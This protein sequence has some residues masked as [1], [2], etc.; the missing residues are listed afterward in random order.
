MFFKFSE[1]AMS[2]ALLD[3][4]EQANLDEVQF[5]LSSGL[6]VNK[7]LVHGQTPLNLSIALGLDNVAVG[8]IE[9]GASVHQVRDCK[10][11]SL[12]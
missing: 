8:L 4:I 12:M 11:S 3:A 5:I 6:N 1:R 10:L 2:E 7:P 9:A